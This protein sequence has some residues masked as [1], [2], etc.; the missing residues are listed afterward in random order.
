MAERA[1]SSE[2]TCFQVLFDEA[3]RK[4]DTIF[5]LNYMR[6]HVQGRKD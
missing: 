4:G 3:Q 1:Y 2:T 6:P 5:H